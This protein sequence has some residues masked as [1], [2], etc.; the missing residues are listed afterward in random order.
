MT[1]DGRCLYGIIQ[2][3]CWQSGVYS[4]LSELVAQ[5]VIHE[6]KDATWTLDALDD[7]SN[8]DIIGDGNPY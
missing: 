3:V 4:D 1:T 8:E 5:G 6:I 7:L 2:N